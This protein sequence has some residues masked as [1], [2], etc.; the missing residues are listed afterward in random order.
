MFKENL[1][2]PEPVSEFQPNLSILERRGFK[3]AQVTEHTVF[4]CKGEII[5]K[6]LKLTFYLFSLFRDSGPILTKLGIKHVWAKG[7]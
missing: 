7:K 2:S 1:F 3:F 6:K 4:N 5:T